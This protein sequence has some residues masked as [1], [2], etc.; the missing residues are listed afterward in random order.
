LP[1]SATNVRV[2]RHEERDRLR[3]VERQ[4]AGYRVMRIT[5]RQIESRPEAVIA[6]VAQALA[7]RA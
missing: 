6:R 4:A 7:A 1:P 5:W 3:D 2:G